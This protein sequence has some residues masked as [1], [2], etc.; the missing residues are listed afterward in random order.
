M[1]SQ[2]R[3]SRMLAVGVWVA[4]IGSMSQ[5]AGFA[6]Y[7]TSARGTAMGEALVGTTEDAS[8]VYNNP[9]NMVELPG[10]QT[11][12]GA[13]LVEPTSTQDLGPAGK[14]TL[15][16]QI[17]TLPHAYATWQA[18]D[19]WWLGLGEFS[20]FGLS[21]AYNPVWPGRFNSVE[22][23]I[24]TFSLNPNVA[25]KISDQLSVAAGLE[26]MYMNI[27]LIKA[28]PLPGPTVPLT[29]TGDSWGFGGDF[30]L[31]WKP[32]EQVG[33]GLV[34]RLPI[35]QQISGDA[36]TPGSPN[37]L[38]GTPAQDTSAEGTIVLPAST[39][40]GVNYQPTKRLNLGAVATYTEWSS[41]D[42]LAIGFNPPIIVGGTPVAQSN[43]EKNWHDVWR[44]GLGAEYKLTAALAVRASYVYDMDPISLAHA[45]YILP[46]GN[47]H[48]IGLGLGYTFDAWSIDAGYSLILIDSESFAARPAEGIAATKSEDGLAHMVGI[49]V[50]RKF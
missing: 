31:D 40:L 20:R 19:R 11:M 3:I 5:G 27:K 46:P 12:L 9:A 36:Y 16:D 26:A 33:I 47:R 15:E 14:Y 39:T 17:F 49:S 32:S 50:G 22:A 4:A 25:Y 42:D 43:S 48:I 2:M 44:F 24:N 35:R 6:L 37:P 41:Y 34:Y 38:L 13:T 28:L 45:D 7:E 1:M 8:A 10:V 21:T 29:L 23:D 30:A 18:D